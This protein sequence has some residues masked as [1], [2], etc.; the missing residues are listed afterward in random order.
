MGCGKSSNTADEKTVS[1][2]PDPIK[3]PTKYESEHNVAKV[4]PMKSPA[5]TSP[6]KMAKDSKSSPKSPL[7]R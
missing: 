7:K 6:L 3:I 2:K 1:K 4:S 5:K